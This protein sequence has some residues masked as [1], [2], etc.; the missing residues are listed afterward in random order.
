MWLQL[1]NWVFVS[2][3]PGNSSVILQIWQIS[4]STLSGLGTGVFCF[5]IIFLGVSWNNSDGKGV[6]VSWCVIFIIGGHFAIYVFLSLTRGLIYPALSVL[7]RWK[8]INYYLASRGIFYIFCFLDKRCSARSVSILF[9][10]ALP[11]S[12]G[13]NFSIMCEMFHFTFLLYWFIHGDPNNKFFLRQTKPLKC[14]EDH[15]NIH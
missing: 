14:N 13:V 6:S 3:P 8:Y 1:T 7:P 2:M 4:V 11:Q 5:S 12:A 15:F 10:S 9:C